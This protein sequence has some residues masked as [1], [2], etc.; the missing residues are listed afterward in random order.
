MYTCSCVQV[1]PSIFIFS[2]CSFVDVGVPA[3]K[4]VCACV[5]VVCVC[6][7]VCVT[8][9]VSVAVGDVLWSE[10]LIIIIITN[11]YLSVLYA[12]PFYS[13][14]C[15]IQMDDHFNVIFGD[16]T[17]LFFFWILTKDCFNSYV[18]YSWASDRFTWLHFY[19]KNYT[20]LRVSILF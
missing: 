14:S 8:E 2:L 7:L 13:M 4:C 5:Y 1:F 12:L 15:V 20:I 18:E 10:M 19:V 16:F 17:C 3:H 6:V 11:I 9:T